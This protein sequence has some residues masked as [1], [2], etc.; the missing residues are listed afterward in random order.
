MKI[1]LNGRGEMYDDLVKRRLLKLHKPET[2]VLD[3]LGT[4]DVRRGRRS[5]WMTG[6]WHS[7]ESTCLV[8]VFDAK[9]AL[10]RYGLVKLTGIDVDCPTGTL[11]PESLAQ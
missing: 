3:L 7:E 4:P 10:R 11:L 9:P 8:A 1:L 2:R 5:Y 6:R